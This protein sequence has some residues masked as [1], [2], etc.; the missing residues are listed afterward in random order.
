MKS[1]SNLVFPFQGSMSEQSV[2]EFNAFFFYIVWSHDLNDVDAACSF[3]VESAA[4]QFCESRKL[5]HRVLETRQ[6]H[7][8]RA[9]FLFLQR[10]INMVNYPLLVITRYKNPVLVL[11]VR[12]ADCLCGNVIQLSPNLALLP[13]YFVYILCCRAVYPTVSNGH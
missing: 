13:L 8:I 12:V 1:G 4:L 9:R 5:S 3:E 6:S 10:K 7:T 11:G 2:C